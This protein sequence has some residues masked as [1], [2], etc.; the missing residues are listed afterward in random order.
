MTVA[1]SVQFVNVYPVFGVAFTVTEEHELNV[2]P[3]VVVPPSD[4]FDINVTVYGP[5]VVKLHT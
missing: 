5:T 1:P 2:P 4:G 3:P